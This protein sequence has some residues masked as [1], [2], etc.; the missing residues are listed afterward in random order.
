MWIRVCRRVGVGDRVVKRFVDFSG[1]GLRCGCCREN[2]FFKFTCS[3]G[4]R[5]FGDFGDFGV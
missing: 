4:F 1:L 2:Y 3:V 5:D